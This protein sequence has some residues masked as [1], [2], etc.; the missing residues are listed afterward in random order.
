V[1]RPDLTDLDGIVPPDVL[2]AMRS[3]VSDT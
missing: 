3:N 2:A 1:R